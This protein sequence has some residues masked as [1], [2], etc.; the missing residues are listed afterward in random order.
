MNKF[1]VDREA[2]MKASGWSSRTID[3]RC[4]QKE[5]RWRPMRNGGRR[6]MAPREYDVLSLPV[7]VQLK[8][9]GASSSESSKLLVQSDAHVSFPASRSKID[10]LNRRLPVTDEDEA[11][12]RERFEQIQEFIDF[13]NHDPSQKPKPRLLGG[14]AIRTHSQMA[15]YVAAEQGM[16]VSEVWRRYKAWKTGSLLRKI[17][18]DKGKS[19]FFEN[20]P[21][22]ADLAAYVHLEQRQSATCAY[23]AIVRDREVLDIPESELPSYETVRLWLRSIPPVYRALAREGRRAYRERMAPY[24]SR[25]YDSAASNEIWVSDHMIHDV[26]VQNDCFLDAGLGTPIR[27]RFTAIIDWHS[28]YVVGWSWAWEG[29][30]RS[31]TTALRHA[32]QEHGPA[33]M[34][35]CDN[36]KDYLKAA[37]GAMPAYLRSEIEPADWC[38]DELRRAEDLGILARLGMAVQHCI[39]RHPQSKH[40]ERF[41]RTMHEQF[42][43]TFPTYTGGSPA[44]RPDF[45]AEAMAQHRKLLRM[46]RADRSKHPPA[47]LFMAMA[48]AWI[49]EYHQQKHR[50]NAMNGRT[51][52]DVFEQDFW[53]H[54]RPAPAP[55]DLALMLM[56]RERRSVR[57]CAVTLNKRRYIGCDEVGRAILH[58]LNE[59]EVLVAYDPLDPQSAAILDL[60]GRLLT[61]ATAEKFLSQSPAANE[62]IAESMAERRRLEKQTAQTILA[63]GNQARAE[64]AVTEVE[65]LA[66]KARMLPMAVG[67]HITQRPVRM[68]ADDKATAPPSAVDI[69]RFLLEEE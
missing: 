31:I 41:F 62:A 8:I 13:C 24:V 59:C 47:S 33:A 67:D 30:S 25:N 44:T 49:Q 32:V 66:R 12:I 48:T 50:G 11:R 18:S 56:E 60:N 21:K 17:R 35:Y 46:G 28:R 22:A 1:W 65:H 51:P 45:T 36:G 23:E 14:K 39:V 52:A 68:R 61:F 64:G 40:V 42:D 9:M 5:I 54:S 63:I 2:L 4:A 19:R 10:S 15:A 27:L 55:Q 20:Y 53:Q 34:L 37:K 3:R 26:E 57:E 6:G 69:A 29:S 58:E 43:K 7:E 38:A 16:S